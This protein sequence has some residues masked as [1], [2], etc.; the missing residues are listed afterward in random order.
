[1]RNNE[2]NLTTSSI[3]QTFL[4][5]VPSLVISGINYSSP[6]PYDVYY[7][8]SLSLLRTQNGVVYVMADNRKYDILPR[9]YQYTNDGYVYVCTVVSQNVSDNV[10]SMYLV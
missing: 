6:T 9:T 3:H 4:T 2:Y 5:K 7:Y 10:G 1:M 8:C